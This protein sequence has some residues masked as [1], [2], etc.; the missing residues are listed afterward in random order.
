MSRECAAALRV[1]DQPVIARR[2][3]Y[4]GRAPPLRQARL[5]FPGCILPQGDKRGVCPA[6][7]RAVRAVVLCYAPCFGHGRRSRTGLRPRG[8]HWPPARPSTTPWAI[9]PSVIRRRAGPLIPSSWRCTRVNFDD[10]FDKACRQGTG[11]RYADTRRLPLH[12]PLCS[13]HPQS[14]PQKR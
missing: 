12:T 4:R 13:N 3:V 2:G 9:T 10:W 1:H 11:P 8:I 6:Q 7:G 14:K 5:P